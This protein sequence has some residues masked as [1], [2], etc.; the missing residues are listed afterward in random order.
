METQGLPT[1]SFSSQQQQQQCFQQGFFLQF[2]ALEKDSSELEGLVGGSGT[3]AWPP[4]LR[5][6]YW[7]PKPLV[8]A[9]PSE[10]RLP[11][12]I[13]MERNRH[14]QIDIKKRVIYC[15]SPK[16][17]SGGKQLSKNLL[18]LLYSLETSFFQSTLYG[19]TTA[20]GDS[21]S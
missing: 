12:W 1:H 20:W 16:N 3:A 9:S 15:H 4:I 10:Q 17:L 6:V 21:S 5:R 14:V 8:F 11:L 2:V 18:F 7:A 19:L 13:F